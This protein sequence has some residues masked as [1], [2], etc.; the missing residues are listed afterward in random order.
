MESEIGRNIF[1]SIRFEYIIYYRLRKKCNILVE[2]VCVC[3]CG[4]LKQF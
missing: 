2:C 4:S 1:S 3:V